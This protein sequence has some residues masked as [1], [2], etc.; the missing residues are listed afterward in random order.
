MVPIGYSRE[1]IEHGIEVLEE[2]DGLLLFIQ[3]NVLLLNLQHILELS[4][5]LA[6]YNH[7]TFR[8]TC[9]SLT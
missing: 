5:L 1:I 2:L 3:F 4:L 6:W 7:T 9:V 8:T